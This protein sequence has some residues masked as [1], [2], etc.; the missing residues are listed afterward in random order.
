VDF[1]SGI[2]IRALDPTENVHSYVCIAAYRGWIR[3]MEGMRLKN[4]PIGRPKTSII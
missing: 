3:P 4:E 1:Y 2:I